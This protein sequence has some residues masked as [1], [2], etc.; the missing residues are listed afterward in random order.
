MNR[1]HKSLSVFLV[2]VFLITLLPYIPAPTAEAFTPAHS[3]ARIGLNAERYSWGRP[4][5]VQLQNS[6][7]LRLGTFNANRQFVPNSDAGFTSLT[8]TASGTTVIIR[9][10]AGTTLHSAMGAIA[11]APVDATAATTYTLPHA[12]YGG[13]IRTTF[14]FYGGFRFTSAAAGLTIVNYVDVEQYLKGV[15]PYEAVPSWPIHAL[16]AQAVAART[17]TVRNFGRRS[18]LNFDLGNTTADQVYRGAGGN[19][20]ANTDRSVTDT[21]GRVILH[22]GNPID[23]VY[24][25]ASGGGTENSENVW[26]SAVPYLRGRLDPY[27]AAPAR[28]FHYQI[29]TATQFHQHMRTRDPNGFTLT[30]IVEVTPVYTPTGNMYSVTFRDSGGRTVT[31][32]RNQTRTVIIGHFERHSQ[33]FTINEYANTAA[34]E[35]RW[36]VTNYGFGH[37]VGMPQW[38]AYG[39]ARTGRYTYEDIL[40]FFYTDVTISPRV[41]DPPPHPPSPTG[42][43]DLNPYAWYHDAVYYLWRRM[44]IS[45]TTPTTFSPAAPVTRGMFVTMLGNLAGIDTAHYA[46]TGTFQDVAPGAWYAPHVEWASQNEIVAGVGDGEFQ[47][48]RAVTRQEMAMFLFNYSQARGHVLLDPAVQIDP[49]EPFRDH[50]GIA[51]WALLAVTALH[52][53]GIIS[54][55][56]HGNFNPQGTGNRAAFAALIANFHRAVY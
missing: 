42:F 12:R 25:S 27:C 9:D 24:F 39:M 29:F 33:R 34:G 45:G 56:E 38:S 6:G 16:K 1:L 8:I 10:G 32:R 53:A 7:G 55:D 37:G 35:R 14:R 41:Q 46:P 20:N 44:F 36:K 13:N 49:P 28:I 43:T 23:A 18:G 48:G 31:Y 21:A 3:I 17:F 30:N 2:F 54:G 40:R 47:P 51:E 4:P 19:A 11:V 15:V 5:S 22:N 26:V 52:H 50:A